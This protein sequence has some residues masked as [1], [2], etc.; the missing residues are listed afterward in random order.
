MNS[1]ELIL[2]GPLIHTDGR[3]RKTWK[4]NELNNLEFQ[5]QTVFDVE[6]ILEI[7]TV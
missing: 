2:S 7:I 5:H 1:V 3:E 4:A 6:L